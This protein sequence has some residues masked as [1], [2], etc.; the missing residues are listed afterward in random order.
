ML[1]LKIVNYKPLP[2]WNFQ[3]ASEFS[4]SVD[5]KIRWFSSE[6]NNYE[7]FVGVIIGAPKNTYSQRIS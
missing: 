3:K 1:V 6:T 7:R 4:K 2:R 5:A